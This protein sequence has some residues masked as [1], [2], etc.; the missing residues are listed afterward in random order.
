[1]VNWAGCP[2]RPQCRD[3][4]QFGVDLRTAALRF[5]AAPDVAAALIVGAHTE[6]QVLA[7]V[8]FMQ[9]MI[10]LEFWVELKRQK[11]IEENA[12]TPSLEW[13]NGDERADIG[14]GAPEHEI[15]YIK[16]VLLLGVVPVHAIQ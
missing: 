14:A 4:A 8:T 6:E 11:L 9:A 12:P 16:F 10:P 5:S 3:A 1:M 13:N 2:S 7:N 15:P